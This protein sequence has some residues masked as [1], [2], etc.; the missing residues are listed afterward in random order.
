MENGGFKLESGLLYIVMFLNYQS[1]HS[2]IQQ[3]HLG[4]ISTLV[5]LAAL[6]CIVQ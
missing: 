2:F 3:S 6:Q 4:I 1:M 5:W